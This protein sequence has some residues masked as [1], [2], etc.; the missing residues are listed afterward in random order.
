M[1]LSQLNKINRIQIQKAGARYTPGVDVNA[2][3]LQIL[4]LLQAFYALSLS[5]EFK[6]QIEQF[7]EEIRTAWEKAPAITLYS[8]KRIKQSPNF[9]LEK[10]ERLK[11]NKP[12]EFDKILKAIAHISSFVEK[13]LRK[14]QE[15]LWDKERATERD[16]SEYYKIRNDSNGTSRVMSSIYNLQEYINSPAFNLI[17]KNRLFLTGEWGTGKT[18]FFCDVTKKRMDCGLPTLFILAHHIP[19]RKDP[20]EGICEATN[21]ARD[22]HE[23]LDGLQNLGKSVSQRAIILI[24]GINESDLHIWKHALIPLSKEIRKYSNIGLAIIDTCINNVLFKA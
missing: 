13:K 7:Q 6:Q 22:K 20:L 12:G 4:P 14:C 16:S 2:P 17:N 23:L 5:S 8:F 10:L 24:D 11:N 3:N 15:A 9:L 1:D 19:N 21:I 18:H